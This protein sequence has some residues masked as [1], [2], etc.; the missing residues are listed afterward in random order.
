MVLRRFE[1]RTLQH[2]IRGIV[3]KPILTRLKGADDG[4]AASAGVRRS[5]LAGGRVATTDVSASRAAAKVEPPAA[6]D[7]AFDATGPAGRNRRVDLLLCHGRQA[8]G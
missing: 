1:P 8:Y 4:V 5:V 6:R 2:V 7:Q 3:V